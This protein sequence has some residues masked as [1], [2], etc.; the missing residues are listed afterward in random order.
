MYIDKNRKQGEGRWAKQKT[1]TTETTRKRNKEKAKAKP[2][3]QREGRGRQSKQK[4]TSEVS[5]GG[6]VFCG[7][8][9]GAGA[10]ISIPT[11]GFR[12]WALEFQ[13][14]C[15]VSQG[16]TVIP[17]RMRGFSGWELSGAD[18]KP[19]R[20]LLTHPELFKMNG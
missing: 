15:G 13:F 20:A 18:T 10:R 1:A 17:I 3:G 5:G 16:G 8:P 14:P 7:A 9:S 6:M 19:P 2:K 4:P 11:R 12:G